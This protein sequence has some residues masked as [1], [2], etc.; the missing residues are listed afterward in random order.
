MV[1]S[2]PQGAPLAQ[3]RPLVLRLLL[4]NAE[5]G[6]DNLKLAAAVRKRLADGFAAPRGAGAATVYVD[7]DEMA[8]AV[9]PAGT[10]TVAGKTVSVRLVFK[11][12]GQ[13]LG[14]V[15]VDGSTDDLPAL[16][17]KVAEAIRRG[18]RSP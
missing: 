5:D 9:R 15:T 14:K 18:S 10:Y 12:D 7:A 16:A 8:G 17:S 13:A 2:H 4:S 1:L 11:R 3:P 6:D